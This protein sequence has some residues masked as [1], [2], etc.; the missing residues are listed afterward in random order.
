LDRQ[1][2]RLTPTD[3]M[4][5]EFASA[6]ALEAAGDYAKAISALRNILADDK[7]Q[8]VQKNARALFDKIEKRAAESIAHAKDLQ[9][10]G[11]LA[12]ALESLNETQRQFSGLQASK[13]AIE[14]MGKIEQA[15]VELRTA[16]RNKRAQD[17]LA[18]AQEFYK[19]KDYIPCLDRCE[20]L[21][22]NYGDL[23]E[24]QRAFALAG[25]IKNNTEWLQNAADVMTER[26]ASAWLALADS[27]L[28]HGEPRKAEHYMQRVIQAFPGSRLAESAQ[29]RLT[30]LQAV[31][32]A[33]PKTQSAGP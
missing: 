3:G 1:V 30:Q 26:L 9:G 10:K 19:T 6:Q 12:E 27:Y 18:Q 11:Q 2:A 13:D 33:S 25:Q 17:L 20:I 22:A 29:I 8:A 28:K 5:K 23:P 4:Q 32:P 15:N 21:L 24:G 7:G 31:M 16:Q 14:L